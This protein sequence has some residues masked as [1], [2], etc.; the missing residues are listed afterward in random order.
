[1]SEKTKNGLPRWKI[2]G[3]VEV[4]SYRVKTGSRFKEL[5]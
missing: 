1:M 3:E 2:R 5:P 4:E